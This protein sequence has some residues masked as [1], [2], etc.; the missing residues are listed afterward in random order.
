MAIATMTLVWIHWHSLMDRHLGSPL[1][2]K[3][4]EHSLMDWLSVAFLSGPLFLNGLPKF[5]PI[6]ECQW[7]HTGVIVA[8]ANDEPFPNF[9]FYGSVPSH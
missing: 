4:L 5:G 9:I 8:I 3:R 2:N 6:T 7:I 1:R